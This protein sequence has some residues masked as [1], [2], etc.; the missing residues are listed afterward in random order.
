MKYNKNEHCGIWFRILK[1]IVE[2]I[3]KRF[4]NFFDFE[5][6]P[7]INNFNNRKRRVKIFSI[8]IEPSDFQRIRL[9]NVLFFYKALVL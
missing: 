1:L 6:F 2:D 7:Y 9:L 4:N 3:D 8:F 5:V